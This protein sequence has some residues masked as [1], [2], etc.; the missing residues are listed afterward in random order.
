M[1]NLD[2]APKSESIA[3]EPMETTVCI[4]SISDVKTF[5]NFATA[6]KCNLT[7]ESGKY[8]VDAKS[9]MGIFSLDL[10][11]PIKLILEV[12]SNKIDDR[13]AFLREINN[14]VVA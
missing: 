7:L 9:I 5:V 10:S 1:V 13:K 11:K 3:S 12:G 2:K 4:T 14:F 8:A 6:H